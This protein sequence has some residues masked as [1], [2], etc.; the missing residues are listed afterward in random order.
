MQVKKKQLEL[1]REQQ[2]G[3][4]LG[5]EYIKAIY[6]HPG[7]LTSLQSTSS[8]ILGWHNSPREIPKYI[9]TIIIFKFKKIF[10]FFITP[11]IFIFITYY[12]LAK[13]DPIF[14]ANFIYIFFLIFVIDFVLYF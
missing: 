13:K 6:C 12:Y 10:K 1:D 4:Q 9:F 2:T 14:K 3:S 11:L 7:Y 5:K 8:K